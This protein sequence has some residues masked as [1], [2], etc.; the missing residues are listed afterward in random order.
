MSLGSLIL[1]DTHGGPKLPH[2]FITR[3]KSLI[4]ALPH[5]PAESNGRLEEVQPQ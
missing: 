1:P 3:S 4:I 2:P 5:L